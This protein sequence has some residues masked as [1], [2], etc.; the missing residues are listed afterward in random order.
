[1]NNLYIMLMKN[2]FI[3]EKTRKIIGYV[4]EIIQFMI[5]RDCKAIVI[6]CNTATS[7]AVAL[8]KKYMIF[9]SLEWNLQ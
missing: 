6:A 5:D 7:A 1:M 3:W 8:M 2:M 4:D 9:L